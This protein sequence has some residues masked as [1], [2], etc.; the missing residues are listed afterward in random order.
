[1]HEVVA[2]EPRKR[3][4]PS[5]VSVDVVKKTLVDKR[6]EIVISGKIAPPSHTIWTTEVLCIKPTTIHSYAVSE[7]YGLRN[8]IL[9]EDE[10][11]ESTINTTDASLDQSLNSTDGSGK[12]TFCIPK[13][14]FESLLTEKEVLSGK[15]RV[16]CR[17]I[18]KEKEWEEKVQTALWN[19][20]KLTHG[21][22]FKEHYLRKDGSS[23]CLKS[24]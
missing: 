15:K 12:F 1:M 4:K 21:F 20:C 7:R 17:T 18:L 23:G 13:S 9:R 10:N 22:S 3:G 8:L 5:T 2:M 6:D 14:E 16:R 24:V 19:C 11:L